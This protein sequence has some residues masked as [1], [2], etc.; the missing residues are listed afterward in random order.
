M[1]F[2]EAITG[3]RGLTSLVKG[4]CE[5]HHGGYALG[6]TAPSALSLVIQ[7]ALCES[8]VDGNFEKTTPSLPNWR[9]DEIDFLGFVGC[10]VPKK[11]LGGIG[12]IFGYLE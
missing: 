2:V 5:Y 3:F 6:Q 11:S 10:F 1:L 9:G 8:D 12:R 7:E 4:G